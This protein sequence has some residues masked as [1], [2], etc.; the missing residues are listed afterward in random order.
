MVTL[1]NSDLVAALRDRGVRYGA[2]AFVDMHGKPK[3]KVVPI[4]HLGHAATGSE[5]F[6]GA[7]L[8][9]VPQEVNVEEVAAMPDL[10]SPFVLPTRQ[11]VAYFPSSLYYEGKPFEACSRGILQRQMADAATDGLV[12]KTGVETEFFLLKKD[13]ATGRATP[14]SAADDLAKPCY[15]L[16]GILR[17]FTLVDQIVSTMNDLGWGVYSF[18]HEDANGQFEIDWGYSDAV[19]TADRLTFFRLMVS[20]LAQQHGAIAS[21]MPKPVA[22]QTGSGGHLNMSIADADGQN[23][24][25]AADDPQGLGLSKLGYHFIAGVL[26]HAH[27]ICAVA[28][29]TVNSYKRLLR[30]TGNASG[31]TWA[32]IFAS[33]GGNNRTNMFR[34][35]LGGGRVECRA[36][37]SAMNC[38]LTSAL[39]LAAGLEGIRGNAEV[40]AP[41]MDNLYL[42]SEDQLRSRGVTPLPG[43]L[44][45]ALDAFAADPLTQTVFGPDMHAAYLAEKYAEWNE[46]CAHV[47][48]WEIDRY[49]EFF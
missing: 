44:G 13:A 38:Y 16:R 4:D 14:L 11:D 33:Y 8:D 6:T 41:N 20:E 31:F 10:N 17:N 43:S 27:A 3:A 12:F 21:F 49:L 46:Y 9:G 47:S 30:R 26:A 19:A 39:M 48:D 36:A 28:A 24:F 5:L 42:V 22:G 37:D 35:P 1:T 34:I 29:P 2:I 25:A 15:D 45:E 40:G 18:D 23:L 7:A 32:P